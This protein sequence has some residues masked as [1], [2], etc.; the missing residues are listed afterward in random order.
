MSA[1]RADPHRARTRLV[2]RIRSESEIASETDQS[3]NRWEDSRPAPGDMWPNPARTGQPSRNGQA[4][5]ELVRMQMRNPAKVRE[6]AK[7]VR[8][9]AALEARRRPELAAV[10]HRQQQRGPT[11]RPSHRVVRRRTS[12]TRAGPDDDPGE[13]ESSSPP[14]LI[15]YRRLDPYGLVNAPL[16]AFLKGVAK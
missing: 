8:K 11:T 10:P 2:D 3:G 7:E 1:T 5:I 12:S 6:L 4:V 9:E 16:A 15:G 13:P 14:V